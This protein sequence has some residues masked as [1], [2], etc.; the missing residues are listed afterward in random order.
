LKSARATASDSSKQSAT[1]NHEKGEGRA[2]FGG[3]TH[4][5]V[6]LSLLK[7]PCLIGFIKPT[8][9]KKNKT[10]RKNNVFPKLFREE[11]EVIP[12]GKLLRNADFPP[13]PPCFGFHRL[14][15]QGF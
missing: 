6:A 2:A 8:K 11:K 9:L 7:W 12:Y 3:R 5:K 4:L 14:K 13:F 1:N 15:R 10:G